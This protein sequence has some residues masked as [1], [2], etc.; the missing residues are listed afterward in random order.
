[1]ITFRKIGR[2]AGDARSTVER[3]N[4]GL[5]KVLPNYRLEIEELIGGFFS[6]QGSSF[7]KNFPGVSLR[8]PGPDHMLKL[9]DWRLQHPQLSTKR[10]N[11]RVFVGIGGGRRSSQPQLEVAANGLQN[12]RPLLRAAHLKN[13]TLSNEHFC[14]DSR[15]LA[16]HYCL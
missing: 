1:V 9:Q 10:R 12:I 13:I 2:P 6:R 4:H 14:S 11:K 7:G 3:L 8:L 5:A 16:E 15:L